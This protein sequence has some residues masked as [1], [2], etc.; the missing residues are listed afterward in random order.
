MTTAAKKP[1]SGGMGFASMADLIRERNERARR[2]TASGL[3][4]V[5]VEKSAELHLDLADEGN[6]VFISVSHDLD[7]PICHEILRIAAETEAYDTVVGRD[8]EGNVTDLRIWNRDKVKQLHALLHDAEERF[9]GGTVRVPLKGL[10]EWA[11]NRLSD[12][13]PNVRIIGDDLVIAKLKMAA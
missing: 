10:P 7:E 8:T 6:Y 1:V 4:Q 2:K 13:S 5:Q 3:D 12:L 11:M 9:K